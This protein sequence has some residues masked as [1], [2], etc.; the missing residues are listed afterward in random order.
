MYRIM[1]RL[2]YNRNWPS[3]VYGG[4][5]VLL[6]LIHWRNFFLKMPILFSCLISFGNCEKYFEPLYMNPS[7]ALDSLKYTVLIRPLLLIDILPFIC[8]GSPL[9]LTLNTII[10][11]LNATNWFTDNM[12][13]LSRSWTTGVSYPHFHTRS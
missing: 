5:L 8:L 13:A 4:M 9:T 7:R 11:V 2:M 3:C 12:S 1:C 6:V 10:I